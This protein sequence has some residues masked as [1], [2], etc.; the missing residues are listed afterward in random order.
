MMHMLSQTGGPGANAFTQIDDGTYFERLPEKDA[1]VQIID[2]YRLRIEDEYTFHGDAGGFYA[3]EVPLPDFRRYLNRAEKRVCDKMVVDRAQWS[4]WY[5]AVEN[6]D[7]MQHYGDNM[8]PMKLR[9]VAE[10]VEGSNV[11]AR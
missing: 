10:K 8:M 7:I 6:V 1:F 2:S 4:D 9:M 11:M 5:S 3:G